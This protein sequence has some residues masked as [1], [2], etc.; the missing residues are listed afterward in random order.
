MHVCVQLGVAVVVIALDRR[1]LDGPVHSFDLAVCPRMLDLGQ[2]MLNVML[3]RPDRRYDGRRIW[4]AILV[5]WM[6]LSVSTVWIE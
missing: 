2:S 4:C 1:F 6:P 3:V 5:N